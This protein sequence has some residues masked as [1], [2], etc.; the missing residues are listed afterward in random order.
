MKKIKNAFLTLFLATTLIS[1]S[2]DDQD[3]SVQRFDR[4]ITFKVIGE[5][6]GNLNVAYANPTDNNGVTPGEVLS[7]IPWQKN[8]EYAKKIKL[9]AAYISGQNGQPNEIVQLQVFSNGELIETE[10]GI[11][12]DQGR[13]FVETGII[14]FK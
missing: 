14:Y 3:Y 2:D 13:I 9:T 11:A 12:D 10:I 7:V 6:S 5:Y 4:N 8:I 1:C